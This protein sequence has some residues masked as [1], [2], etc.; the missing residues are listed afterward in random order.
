MENNCC[1]CCTESNMNMKISG[2]IYCQSCLE[3]VVNAGKAFIEINQSNLWE[4]LIHQIFIADFS[5][6]EGDLIYFYET[7]FNR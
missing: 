1:M 3:H 7:K 5:F 4:S 6:D 2:R